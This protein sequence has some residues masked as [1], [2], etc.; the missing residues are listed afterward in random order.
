MI[1]SIRQLY[2]NGYPP[3]KEAEAEFDKYCLDQAKLADP[4]GAN[5]GFCK[6]PNDFVDDCGFF[7]CVPLN[8]SEIKESKQTL[9]S[10]PCCEKCYRGEPGNNHVKLFGMGDR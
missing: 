9:M 4:T 3:S 5:C 6:G 10:L 2:A 8:Y 1:T 7:Y